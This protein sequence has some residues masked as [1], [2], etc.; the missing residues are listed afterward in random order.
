MDYTTKIEYDLKFFS[1]LSK[2]HTKEEY[3]FQERGLTAR[4]LESYHAIIEGFEIPHYHLDLI[5]RVDDEMGWSTVSLNVYVEN[6]GE[7]NETIDDLWPDKIYL[8]SLSVTTKDFALSI[9]MLRSYH[10]GLYEILVAIESD[11]VQNIMTA[12]RT[13]D[14]ILLQTKPIKEQETGDEHGK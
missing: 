8:N 2:K 14:Q 6:P 10:S 12:K 11:S 4:A 7:E 3:R 9:K 5:A 13:I 1:N